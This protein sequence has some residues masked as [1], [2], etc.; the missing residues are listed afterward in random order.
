MRYSRGTN[1]RAHPVLVERRSFG[2][3]LIPSSTD[4]SQT[5]AIAK[6]AQDIRLSVRRMLDEPDSLCG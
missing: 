5:R 1:L 4:P 2:V 6:R 3:A